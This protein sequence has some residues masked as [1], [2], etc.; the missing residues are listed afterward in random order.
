MAPSL[1]TAERERRRR[2]WRPA[3]KSWNRLVDQL[4]GNTDI[5]HRLM[6]GT[7]VPEERSTFFV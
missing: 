2:K 7:L 4:S 6:L 5:I 3:L 1:S